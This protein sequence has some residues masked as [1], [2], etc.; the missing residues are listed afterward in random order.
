M[1]LAQEKAD[2]VKYQLH[3]TL[4]SVL[5]KGESL[6]ELVKRSEDLSVTTKFFYKDSKK[7]N[8]CPC[9]VM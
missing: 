1:S 2:H 4:E 5:A 3:K 6:G 9:V 7:L 8:K